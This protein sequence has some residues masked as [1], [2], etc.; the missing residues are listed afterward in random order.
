M[1][2]AS[3][4]LY[5]W[6]YN[7]F[8]N[9]MISKLYRFSNGKQTASDKEHNNSELRPESSRNLKECFRSI[10]P[11]CSKCCGPNRRD[12]SFEIGRNMIEHETNIV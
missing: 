3:A 8:D 10:I 11:F 12:R 4:F 1:S 9:Y 5:A 2:G 6:S 7:S